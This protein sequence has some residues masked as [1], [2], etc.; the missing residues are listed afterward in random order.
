MA[1]IYHIETTNGVITWDRDDAGKEANPKQYFVA[2]GKAKP[3]PITVR[4]WPFDK[5]FLTHGT[6]ENGQFVAWKAK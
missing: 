3:E 1:K 4:G 6:E 2:R 5:M